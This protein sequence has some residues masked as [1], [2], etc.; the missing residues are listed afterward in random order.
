MV[1]AGGKIYLE[2]LFGRALINMLFQSCSKLSDRLIWEHQPKKPKY[3]TKAL[4]TRPGQNGK[5]RMDADIFDAENFW[6]R[7]MLDAWIK[8]NRGIEKFGG[9]DAKWHSSNPSASK[10]PRCQFWRD[11]WPAT[12]WRARVVLNFQGNAER[13]SQRLTESQPRA[14]N[15]SNKSTKRAQPNPA[16]HQRD[17]PRTSKINNNR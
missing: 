12:M 8:F 3:S 16:D 7:S 2:R 15:R 6:H 11:L 14:L 4:T 17:R 10:R 5:R 9:R 1:A 13:L